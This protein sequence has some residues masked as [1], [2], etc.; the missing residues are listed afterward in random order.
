MARTSVCLRWRQR[1]RDKKRSRFAKCLWFST[2]DLCP[3]EK[4]SGETSQLMGE[5]ES[6]LAEPHAQEHLAILALAGC[7]LGKKGF[8]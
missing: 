4:A 3:Q 7:A 6:G 5:S 8:G 2:L 1:K